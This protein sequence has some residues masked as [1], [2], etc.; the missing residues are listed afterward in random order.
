[1][2]AYIDKFINF[3]RVLIITGTTLK[4]ILN[5]MKCQNDGVSLQE[6]IQKSKKAVKVGIIATVLPS[7]LPLIESSFFAGMNW[8]TPYLGAKKLML[9]VINI[10]L[11]LEP[12]ILIYKL[13]VELLAY[14]LGSEETRADHKNNIIKV[15]IV[16]I[17]IV[18]ATVIVNQVLSY[19][20]IPE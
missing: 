9:S 14:K 5:L 8:S 7:L 1:M 18:S 6:G 2:E 11:I 4:V 12:V 15:I 19:Y 3:F 10:L 13:A 17:L 20:E 16:G